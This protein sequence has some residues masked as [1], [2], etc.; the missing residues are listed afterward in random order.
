V[1]S[2]ILNYFSLLLFN[3]FSSCD[4][5]ANNVCSAGKQ[6]VRNLV[7]CSNKFNNQNSTI[8]QELTD[9]AAY[10]TAEGLFSLTWC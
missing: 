10:V 5:F 8:D 6:C 4:T 2:F 1:L 9:S 7:V 3:D